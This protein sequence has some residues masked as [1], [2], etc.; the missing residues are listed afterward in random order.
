VIVYLPRWAGPGA[1][2]YTVAPPNSCA[3]CGV[4][5]R[6]HGR[7]GHDGHADADAPSGYVTPSDEQRKARMYARYLERCIAEMFR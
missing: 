6:E 5:W 2:P 3:L 4:E 1:G 7:R